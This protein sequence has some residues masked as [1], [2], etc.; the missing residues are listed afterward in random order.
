MQLRRRLAHWW[1]SLSQDA[2]RAPRSMEAR[3][4]FWSEVREGEQEA[5]RRA[6]R[7]P[8]DASRQTPPP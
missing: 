6:E 8:G 7:N 4:H 5:E 2:P 1:Q 3:D